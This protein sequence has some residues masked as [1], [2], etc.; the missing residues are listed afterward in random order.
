MLTKLNNRIK[1]LKDKFNNFKK[2]VEKL[3]YSVPVQNLVLGLVYA[4]RVQNYCIMGKKSAA[5]YMML[6]FVS[7]NM[8]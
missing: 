2:T 7:D 8:Q 3:I 1:V 5:W 4:C 6:F